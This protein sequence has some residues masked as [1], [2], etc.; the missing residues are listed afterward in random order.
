MFTLDAQTSV[1]QLRLSGEREDG[2]TLAQL[3][4][5][6]DLEHYFQDVFLC[7]MSHPGFVL[8]YCVSVLFTETHPDYA[9][10]FTGVFSCVCVPV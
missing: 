9:R 8:K 6:R 1:C 5:Q 10:S 7:F 2:F 4:S 3:M